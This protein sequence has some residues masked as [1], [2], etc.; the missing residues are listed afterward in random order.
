MIYVFKTSEI[1]KEEIHPEIPKLVRNMLE[2]MSVMPY[3]FQKHSYAHSLYF[4]YRENH[5]YNTLLDACQ[6]RLANIESSF[7]E[8]RKQCSTMT[9]NIDKLVS[10]REFTENVLNYDVAQYLKLFSQDATHWRASHQEITDEIARLIEISHKL[11]KRFDSVNRRITMIKDE[12]ENKYSKFAK[13][14]LDKM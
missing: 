1:L 3:H 4:I 11:C 7:I 12:S 6:I 8:V 10:Q 13:H 2:N 14:I 5:L 9:G